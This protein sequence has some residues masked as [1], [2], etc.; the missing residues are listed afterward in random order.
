LNGLAVTETTIISQLSS[1][2][3]RESLINDARPTDAS[4]L[5]FIYLHVY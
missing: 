5:A 4:D 2:A 1:R 3:D